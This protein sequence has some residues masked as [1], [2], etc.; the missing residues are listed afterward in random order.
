MK[1]IDILPCPICGKQ[2]KFR[3]RG[4]PGHGMFVRI[5]C[6]PL[7]RKPHLRVEEGKA[8]PERAYAYAV[9]AWNWEAYGIDSGQ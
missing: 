5:Q 7:F 9:N 4:A 3:Y 1:D 8:T 6:K 2:P